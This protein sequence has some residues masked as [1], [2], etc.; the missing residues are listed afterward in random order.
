MVLDA[1]VER[2]RVGAEA[3]RQ[4][5][6]VVARVAQQERAVRAALEHRLGAHRRQRAPVPVALHAFSAERRTSHQTRAG[7]IISIA[8]RLVCH[9]C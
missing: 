2:A 4:D 5:V 7:H 3:E 1:R 9:S 6:L 8:T